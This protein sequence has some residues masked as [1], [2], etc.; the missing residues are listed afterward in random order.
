MLPLAPGQLMLFA[1]KT[2]SLKSSIKQSSGAW[3]CDVRR[4]ESASFVCGGMV[5]FLIVYAWLAIV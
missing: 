4:Q 2:L 5:V 1:N 3:L